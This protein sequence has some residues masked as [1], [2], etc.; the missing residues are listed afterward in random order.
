M[1][2]LDPDGDAID[3]SG[4]KFA[5]F[6]PEHD[7]V[8]DSRVAIGIIIFSDVR[9]TREALAA[10]FE[11]NSRLN[12]KGVA[13]EFGELFEQS[14]ALHPDIVLIDTA[15]PDGLAA[16]RRVKQIAPWVR[17]V[18]F[19]LA[20]R[21]DAVIAWAEAG[22]SAYIPRSAGLDELV[23]LLERAMRDEQF[24]S[25]RVASGLLRRIAAGRSALPTAEP[26]PLT[27]RE[28]EIIGLIND[29]LSNKEIARRLDIGVATTKTHVHNAL[30]KLG[31]ARRSQAAC[32]MREQACTRPGNH[33]GL[34]GPIFSPTRL[35]R[36]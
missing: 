28:M 4:E 16:V 18:A 31:L 15:F 7:A 19:A 27:L 35:G 25:M 13:G 6:P 32:W 8:A 14:L 29:G 12:V 36:A 22:V 30:A 11:R 34:G 20:E 23:P 9:F 5:S 17:V 2:R 24:C 10:I 1:P 26:I 21:E 33:P 3:G